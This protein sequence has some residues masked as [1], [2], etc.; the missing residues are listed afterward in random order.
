[1]FIQAIEGVS[2]ETPMDF[3]IGMLDLSITLWMSNRRIAYLDAKIF[4]VP[5]EGIASKLGPIISDDPISDPKSID[6]ELEEFY[7]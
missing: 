7:Y 2:L 1:M 6:D 4:V 3:C 5:S